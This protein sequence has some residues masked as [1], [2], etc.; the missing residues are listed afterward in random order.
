MIRAFIFDL[1]GTLVNTEPLFSKAFDLIGDRYQRKYT[2][3]IKRSVMAH[4]AIIALTKIL[5]AWDLDL[6]PAVFME[7]FESVYLPL[8]RTELTL[9]PGFHELISTLDDLGIRR[10]LS[11]SS[12]RRWVDTIFDRFGLH[13]HFDHVVTADDVL[14]GKPHPEAFS[15]VIDR[16]GFQPSECA[17]IEDSPHGIASAKA[18]GAVT[19]AV[20]GSFCK[21]ADCGQA[22]YQVSSLADIT[23]EFI[24]SMSNSQET[25]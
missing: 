13:Q 18:A 3:E 24:V 5:E 20:P 25:A 11:T 15:L 4:K 12:Q 2:E 16:Y 7:E 9:M 22:D 17:A 23:K 19:I 1:D 6:D 21:T 14:H 8:V 10:S